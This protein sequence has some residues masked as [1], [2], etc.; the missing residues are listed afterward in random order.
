MGFLGIAEVLGEELHQGS[1]TTWVLGWVFAHSEEFIAV[2]DFLPFEED[3]FYRLSI[4]GETAI[5]MFLCTRQ[6]FQ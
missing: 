6:F 2:V 4:D 1:L 3:F 5:L